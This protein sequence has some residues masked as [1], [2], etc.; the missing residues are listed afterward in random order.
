MTLLTRCAHGPLPFAVRNPPS[1]TSTRLS[2][3]GHG[4]A[5]DR[6]TVLAYNLVSTNLEHRPCLCRPASSP[7]CMLVWCPACACPG[8]S[9]PA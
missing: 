4:V 6:I 2:V 7:L 8:L 1:S 5:L 3:P 9:G